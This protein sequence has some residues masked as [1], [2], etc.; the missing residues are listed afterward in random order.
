MLFFSGDKAFL[1]PTLPPLY[2][3]VYRRANRVRSDVTGV[4]KPPSV[5]F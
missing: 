3:T 4:H 1:T 5:T 2:N